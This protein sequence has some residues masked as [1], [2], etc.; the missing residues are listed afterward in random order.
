MTKETEIVL[1]RKIQYW[2]LNKDLT[3][4]EEEILQNRATVI[5]PNNSF[6]KKT[7]ESLKNYIKETNSAQ[8]SEKKRPVLEDI[9]KFENKNRDI[10]D[11]SL[12]Y[13]I[14]TAFFEN[15]VNDF[16]KIIFAVSVIYD[17][18]YSYL[19][20]KEELEDISELIF[21]DRYKIQNIKN[22]FESIY[23]E[24]SKKPLTATQKKLMIGAG[25]LSAVALVALPILAVGGLEASAA[26][27]TGA[28]AAIG[29]ADM[30]VGVGMLA[31]YSTLAC[32]SIMGVTYASLK[33]FEKDKIKQD[34]RNM[35]L[36]S[37]TKLL[38]LKALLFEEAKNHNIPENKLKEELSDLLTLVQDFKS[39]TDYMLFVEKNKTGDNTSKINMFHNFDNYM[40]KV[41]G[42]K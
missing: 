15:D 4:I 6:F 24:L 3:R 10:S 17:D 19:Y 12:S 36:D 27:S 41:C 39:D 21:K 37:A 23:R 38:T 26:A 29:F 30:Q 22:K 33:E 16:A 2:R 14:F 28:L 7:Y 35:D 25:A 5:D 11:R 32:G 13:D 8:L 1:L 18:E 31:L 40:M 34:F 20:P 9:E 42:I